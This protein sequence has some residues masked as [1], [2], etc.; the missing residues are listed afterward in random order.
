[1]VALGVEPGPPAW[2]RSYEVPDSPAQSLARPAI[3]CLY[4]PPLDD[5][6]HHVGLSFISLRYCTWYLVALGL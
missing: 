4:V 1:M 6:M 5:A 2:Q 3:S